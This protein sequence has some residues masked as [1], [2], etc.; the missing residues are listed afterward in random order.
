M[1]KIL[2]II[3]LLFAFSFA[4]AQK[5]KLKKGKVL[6]DGKELF[7]YEKEAMGTEFYMYD[8]KTDALIL[9]MQS[10]DNETRGYIEDDFTKIYFVKEKTT[11]EPN[12]L[13]GYSYKKTIEKLIKRKVIDENG[14]ISESKLE[15]FADQYDENI[16]NRTIRN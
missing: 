5:I 8:L 15:E 1:K 13:H 14:N 7:K 16:T 2:S 3:F 6:L 4:N 12:A 11:I 9:S 10:M